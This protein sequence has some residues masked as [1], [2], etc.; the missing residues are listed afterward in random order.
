MAAVDDDTLE[1]GLLRP[2]IKPDDSVIK[3][4][5]SAFRARMLAIC[6]GLM[7]LVGLGN[8]IFSILDYS[9]NAMLV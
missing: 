8:R 1:T 7:L 5:E 9:D 3:A 4:D 2:E 6:F